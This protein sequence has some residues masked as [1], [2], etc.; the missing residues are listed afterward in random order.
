MKKIRVNLAE[1]F[2][3][4]FAATGARDP[5]AEISDEDKSRLA[6]LEGAL[7]KADTLEQEIAQMKAEDKSAALAA[8]EEEVASLQAEKV[9]LEAKVQELEAKLSTMPAAE[10]TVIE[11]EDPKA[12]SSKPKAKSSVEQELDRL[13][14]INK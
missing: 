9:S 10:G 13:M 5:F 8:K 1:D 6:L 3:K 2:P 12:S 7:A 14:G 4:Y 11:G